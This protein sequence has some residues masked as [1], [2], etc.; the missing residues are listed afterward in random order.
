[1]ADELHENVL[2]RS[3][4]VRIADVSCS[5]RHPHF[6]E[7]EMASIPTFVFVRRGVFVKE[8]EGSETLADA[9]QIVF[10]NPGESYRVRHP[11]Q[12]GDQCTA[13]SFSPEPVR[14]CLAEMGGKGVE[15][16][17]AFPVPCTTGDPKS[18]LMQQWLRR[19]LY[20]GDTDAFEVE[21]VCM[22]LLHR[23][24]Q[25]RNESCQARPPRR[26]GTRTAH[27]RI[28]RRARQF[29]AAHTGEAVSLTATSR[30]TAC[31]PYH[32][33]R[34]FHRE[35]GLTLHRY[36]HRL[37]LR[38][39]LERLAEDRGGLTEIALDHGFSSHGHFTAAF[40]REFGLSPSAFRRRLKTASLREMS[41][42]LEA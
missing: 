20:R 10:F 11:V 42:N 32:L 37:R 1:M 9:N 12:G 39:A 36:H 40:H 31:S 25:G 17:E 38:T 2:F 33:A 35:V 16:P 24:V 34:I 18:V 7:W 4:I 23:V 14:D 22:R 30:A 3:P 21:S 27:R 15:E 26:L 28:A 13:F 41:K 6:G 19:W 8:S 5:P 29:L